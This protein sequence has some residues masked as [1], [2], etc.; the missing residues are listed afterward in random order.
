MAE[1]S[2]YKFELKEIAQTLL[3]K[4]GIHSG[5]WTIGVGFMVTG[6]EAGPTPEQIRPAMIVSI[7]HLLLTAATQ[8]GPLTVEAAPAAAAAEKS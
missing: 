8:D 6:A 3:A 2:Q 7:D 1:I 5:K 4:Q